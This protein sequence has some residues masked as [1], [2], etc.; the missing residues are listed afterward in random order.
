MANRVMK[1]IVSPIEKISFFI[2]DCFSF[3]E[4]TP[5]CIKSKMF[6][7]GIKKCMGLIRYLYEINPELFAV[8]ATGLGVLLSLLGFWVLLN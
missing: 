5:F 8:G 2:R 3:C 4:Y 6:T 1:E 7:F